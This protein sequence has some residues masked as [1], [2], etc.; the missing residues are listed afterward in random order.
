LT[1]ADAF[2]TQFDDYVFPA[3][4]RVVQI[5]GW[6]LSTIKG[7]EYTQS[8]GVLDYEPRFTVEGDKN[9]VYPSALSVNTPDSYF[10]NLFDYNKLK[11]AAE[12]RNIIGATPVLELLEEVLEERPL[13]E[14][15]FLS[16]VKPNLAV[17]TDKLLVGVH[18]PVTLG[19]YDS[20]G[21]FTGVTSGQD[22][23][24][25]V[26]FITE[27]IPG[28]QYLTFGEGKY[29][30]LPE[31]DVYTFAFQGTGS[32]LATVSVQEITQDTQS[33]VATYADIPVSIATKATFVVVPDVA[34]SDSIH[35]DQNGDGVV[36]TYVAPDLGSLSVDQLLINLTT[37]VQNLTIKDKLR[38]QL[39][40]K[41]TSLQ[42][43]VDKQKQ[44]QSNVLAKLQTQVQ[45]QSG[46]GKIDSASATQISTL[47]EDL[48]SQS[49]TIPLDPVLIN[50]L[51]EQINTL[52][53]TT[54]LKNSLLAKVT[55]LQ[56]LAGVTKSLGSLTVIVTKKGTK[57][58]IPD[59]DVQNMLNLLEQIQNAI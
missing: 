59:A 27:D 26:Q 55:Q 3:S 46:K 54:S 47:V 44:K 14:G 18:S 1:N 25:G 28:S 5:A 43:K 24:S 42:K 15:N 20:Q 23:A 58:Q 57:G 53:I 13:S 51:K 2:H 33:D 45:K 7:I 32:G 21:R 56:N 11:P 4:M 31:G 37:A 12:H 50:Q 36:D 6:G 17:I 8:H 16:K 10:F 30:L 41:I 29:I 38:T 39:S 35:I 48:I 19:A 52:S 22:P 40:N 9:V 49:T 34:Q